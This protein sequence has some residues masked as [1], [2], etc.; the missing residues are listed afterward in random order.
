MSLLVTK[1]QLPPI[2]QGFVTR[3]RLIDKIAAQTHP[4]LVLISAPAGYGKSSLL[5]DW[6]HHAR[7]D[8]AA[9]AWYALDAGDNDPARFVGHLLHSCRAALSTADAPPFSD[10]PNADLESAVA[11]FVNV[12]AA[13]DGHLLLAFD[14]YHLITSAAIHHAV[15]LLLEHLPDNAQIAMSSRADPPLQLSRL[16]ARDQLVE[17]RVADLRFSL[18]EVHNFYRSALSIDLSQESIQQIESASEGWAAAL[19]LLA[20]TLRQS[21]AAD[22]NAAIQAA[23]ADYSSGQ[24]HIFEYFAQEVFEL[25][26]PEI[27]NFLL[28]TCVLNRLDAQI[29]S[30][31][32]DHPA[33]PA[34]LLQLARSGLF[35]ISLTAE[36]PVYRYHHLFQDFLSRHLQLVD[37]ERF[38]RQHRQA[39]KWYARHEGIAEAVRHG[40]S[41][42]DYG[43]AAH[44]IESQAWEVLSASGEIATIVNW[45][46]AFPQQELV[47]HPRLCL[48]FSRALYLIGDIS[49]SAAFVETASHALEATAADEVEVEALRA[50]INSY[51]ATLAAYQGKVQEGFRFVE[52]ALQKRDLMQPLGQVRSLNTLGF[53][54]F[55]REDVPSASAAYEESYELA[56]R[57]NHHYLTTD[58]V[59]YLAKIDLIAGRLAAAKTRCEKWLGQYSPPIAPLSTVMIPLALVYYEQNRLVQ[60]EMML[61]DSIQLARRGNVPDAVWLA[62]AYLAVMLA[63]HGRTTEAQSAIQQAQQVINRYRSSLMQSFLEAAQ[64]RIWLTTKRLDDAAAWAETFRQQPATEHRRTFEQFTLARVYLALKQPDETLA[65]LD[66]FMGEADAAGHTG[67]IVEGEMLRS[68]AHWTNGKSDSALRSL[69]RA[70]RLAQPEHYVRTFLD[71]GQ[72]MLRLLR[73][74]VERSVAADYAASLINIAEADHRGA[75]PSDSLSEREIEVL[76]LLAN[77]ATNQDVADQLVISLGTVKSHINHLMNKLEARNRTEAVARARS[78][79]VLTE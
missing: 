56:L 43:Y 34:L 69:G 7:A 23:L 25:Q 78:L 44:L 51:R 40:L 21:V 15:G 63:Q 58:A 73:Y 1:T 31:L 39:A 67:Y 66:G 9:V 29:C 35:L 24:E 3:Q 52:R 59:Y 75:H 12:I 47:R 16:R 32:V 61:R 57:L 38:R 74:A 71:E 45:I 54:H 41:A 60:A 28:D 18:A 70:L 62:S 48:C 77:G 26:P 13:H 14:D 53:L 33:A 68:L 5:V 76:R 37:S 6:C 19:R 46:A 65:V 42:N 17:V 8:G 36:S 50:V 72:P 4:R 79:G 30:A 11:E 64:A 55:L 27:Q 2:Q 49:Q 20:L 22:E 10:Q